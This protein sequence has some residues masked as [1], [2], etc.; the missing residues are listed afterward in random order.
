VF[1]AILGKALG[2]CGAAF[3]ILDIL[4]GERIHTAAH[5]GVSPAFA[6][7]LAT[8]RDVAAKGVVAE[9][10]R[11]ERFVHHRDAAAGA[12]TVPSRITGK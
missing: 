5:R 3:G 10:R 9:F 11:G 12:S 6:E 1:D 4:D 8:P 2:L 7:F